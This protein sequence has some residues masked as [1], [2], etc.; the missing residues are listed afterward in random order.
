MKKG[1]VFLLNLCSTKILYNKF[2]EVIESSSLLDIQVQHECG[3]EYG[4]LPCSRKL[5]QAILHSNPDLISII[6]SSDYLQQAAV[7]FQSLRREALEIPKIA[8]I[9][10]G[11]PKELIELL[12]H[13]FTDFITPPINEINI[14]PRFWR[15]LEQESI[16][17][18]MFEKLNWKNGSRK[19]IGK[20]CAFLEVLNR[21]SLMA[22]CDATVLISGETGTGKELCAQTIHNLS[23]RCGKPFIPVNCGALPEHLIE[24]ELFGHVKGAYT[25]A[26]DTEK[27]LVAEAEGGTLFLDEIDALSSSAQVKLLRFLQNR[28][29]RPL[30][31][32]KKRNADVRILAATNTDLGKKVKAELFREDLYYRLNVLS[33]HIPPLRERIDDI[34]LI[35]TYFLNLYGRQY[36]HKSLCFSSAAMQK[37]LIYP[38]LGNIREL[39]S[40]IQRVV[41]LTSLSTIQ[42]DDI[43]LPFSYKNEKYEEESFCEAKARTIEEFERTYLTRLMISSNG[44]VTQAAKAARK[45]RR[46][47]QR[48]LRKYDID[49]YTFQA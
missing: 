4:F 22:K 27:G 29:Y 5:T 18:R 44:N 21:I 40:V 38:W 30:G 24:N 41:L 7:L 35:A 36:G 34:P 12:K 8:I 25:S 6:L 49:R 31:C 15:L 23:I 39:E 48:L 3:D 43:E 9:E 20:S 28:E 16:D 46:A 13:D 33:I 19:L 1:K 17:D 26:S 2:Q 10:Q 47:F 45:D 14:I 37:L 11:N 42:P 32:P